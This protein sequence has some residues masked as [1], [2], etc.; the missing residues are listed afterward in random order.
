MYNLKYD[1]DYFNKVP[2]NVSDND[3]LREPQK[4]GYFKV[5][6]H[7]IIN[8]KT[9][10]AILVLPTGVGK[11][12][13]I[14]ILPYGICNGRVL[15][16]TPQITIKDSVVDS[17][18]PY[19]PENFWHKRNIFYNY[20]ESTLPTLIEYN[21]DLKEEILY[22]SN[23]VILNIH[24]L[25][26]RL[27]QSPINKLPN[28]FF[29]MIIIDEAHHST[30]NTWVETVNYFN[31]AKVVKLTSTP[32]RTDGEELAG[33]LVYKYK[34]SQAMAKGY[35]KSLRNIEYIPDKLYFTIDDDDK[36]YTLEEIL[37]ANIKDEDW[38]KRS[39]AYSIDC[40]EK[41]VVESINLLK[42]K[43]ENSKVPHKIIAVACSIKHAEQ[44]KQLYIKHNCRAEVIHSDLDDTVKNTIKKDINNHR[45]DVIINVAMLGEGYDH[46]YLSIAAIFK[47]YKYE[48][49][50][51][52]FIGRVLRI[53]P[54]N[55][56][57]KYLDNIADIVSHKHLYLE[58]LWE[59]Y[60]V[61][62]EES[63][64]IKHLQDSNY[65]NDID[66]SNNNSKTA[67]ENSPDFG[68]AFEKGYGN[69]KTDNYLTTELIKKQQ[70]EERKQKEKIEIL[71]KTLNISYE[72]ALSI[73]NQSSTEDNVIMKRPDIYFANKKK[74]LDNEIREIIVPD[75]ICKYK[76]DQKS[77]TLKDCFLF[78][79][80]YDWI[81]KI[82]KDNG[83]ALAMFFN[84]YL[85]NEIG[86]KRKDW[87]LDDYD[88]A[89]SKLKNIKEY[90]DKILN[91]YVK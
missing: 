33:D 20:K 91:D 13:L 37:D 74:E 50:Y 25:Q 52:Q 68:Y 43:K 48:L 5:Y 38:I 64:I 3:Q 34:I 28:D 2:I 19:N 66:N 79:K 47:P 23:I 27:E 54:E 82:A 58:K 81:T 41:V 10:H 17:L 32:I 31:K 85:K 53:I 89:F 12:G 26:K 55:E 8:N 36:Q 30:A 78:S 49:P 45:I 16:I 6:E 57:N 35:I 67:I 86:S 4:I 44:I 56:A 60:K 84:D 14:G 59:K 90:V 51:E 63:E 46:P 22:S 75:L 73:Y 83:G 9:T 70:E 72:K 1:K 18:D 11:T 61:E 77:F 71:Q 7:F 62:I 65:I 76:I 24:K 29:D 69:L 87:T 88:N 39:V 80:E 15:I 42:S 40:S 21:K